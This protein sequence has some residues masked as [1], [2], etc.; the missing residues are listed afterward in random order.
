[1]PILISGIFTG[2]TFGY[3]NSHLMG[4]IRSCPA[5]HPERMGNTG[6]CPAGISGIG[7]ARP[8][9]PGQEGES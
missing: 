9:Q 3:V 6:G 8:A 1:M 5:H 7:A 4:H 2:T